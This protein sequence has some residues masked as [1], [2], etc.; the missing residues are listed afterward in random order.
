MIGLGYDVFD[1]F[2]IMY[3]DGGMVIYGVYWY[4]MFGILVSYGCI[5]VVVNYVKWL[6]DWVFVGIFVIVYN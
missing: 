4:N 3:Y 5:N 6:F 2:Y 1:V